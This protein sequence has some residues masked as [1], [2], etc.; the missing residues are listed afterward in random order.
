MEIFCP[1]CKLSADLHTIDSV[2]Y[3]RCPDCGWFQVQADK[4]M[5]PCDEPVSKVDRP[6]EP[7][8]IEEPAALEIEPAETESLSEPATTS[9]G[10]PS[11]ASPTP[12]DKPAEPSLDE[13][14]DLDEFEEDWGNVSITLED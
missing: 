6:P 4:S 5:T 7:G 12:S 1:N 9:E 14:E 8:Q 3:I 2:D 13:D 11:A 10:G